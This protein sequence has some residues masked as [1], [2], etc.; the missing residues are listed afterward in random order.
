[1]YGGKWKVRNEVCVQKTFFTIQINF[2]YHK[3]MGRKGEKQKTGIVP[4]YRHSMIL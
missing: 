3:I 1:L 4:S 2:L